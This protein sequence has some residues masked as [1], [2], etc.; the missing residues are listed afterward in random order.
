M[1]FLLA[2]P[3][4]STIFAQ[5]TQPIFPVRPS[6]AV[7]CVGKVIHQQACSASFRHLEI[8]YIMI[9][10]WSSLFHY[11]LKFDHHSQSPSLMPQTPLFDSV[12]TK[13]E[14]VSLHLNF[15]ICPSS[16]TI[17]IHSHLWARPCLRWNICIGSL[18]PC[19][20]LR[21][22]IGELMC[23]VSSTLR[24]PGVKAE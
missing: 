13:L 2:V 23:L 19:G 4:L 24:L 8:K 3:E 5:C 22:N 6:T 7:H 17:R 12:R 1:S 14:P 20:I 16:L 9:L 15:S 21:I 18:M 10:E 11:S